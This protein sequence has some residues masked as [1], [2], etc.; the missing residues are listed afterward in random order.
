VG[1]P[2]RG[3]ADGALSAGMNPGSVHWF[4]SVHQAGEMVRS[5]LQPRDWV[6]VKGS[7]AA[8]MEEFVELLASG[9]SC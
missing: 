4:E 7:R 5:S 3:I 2:A 9:E 1:G 8:K 6:L